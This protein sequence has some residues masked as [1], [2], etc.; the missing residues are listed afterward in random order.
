MPDAIKVSDELLE[1]RNEC[2]RLGLEYDGRFGVERLRAIVESAG[3]QINP[4]LEVKPIL[5]NLDTEVVSSRYRAPR[6]KIPADVQLALRA[7]SG[8]YIGYAN[9]ISRYL[10]TLL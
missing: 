4:M 1:L 2:D 9:T 7:I 3:K 6:H 5:E 8:K 10:E